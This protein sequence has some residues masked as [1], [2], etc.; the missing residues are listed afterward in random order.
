VGEGPCSKKKKNSVFSCQKEK[1]LVLVLEGNGFLAAAERRETSSKRRLQRRLVRLQKGADLHGEKKKLEKP[2]VL[3]GPKKEAD[4]KVF[5]KRP[6][7]WYRERRTIVH[8]PPRRGKEAFVPLK[9]GKVEGGPE[10][11]DWGKSLP[12]YFAGQ[13]EEVEGGCNMRRGNHHLFSHE[14]TTRLSCPKRRCGL[15]GGAGLPPRLFA[16]RREGNGN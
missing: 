2:H 14:V 6:Y 10:R 7:W 4:H 16:G 1:K 9:G 3:S 12:Q 11:P 15:R 13:E 5:S 8:L